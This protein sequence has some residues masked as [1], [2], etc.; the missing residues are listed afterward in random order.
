[1]CV[2]LVEQEQMGPLFRQGAAGERVKGNKVIM[3][4]FDDAETMLIGFYSSQ[5]QQCRSTIDEINTM[6]LKAAAA[7]YS[8]FPLN[9]PA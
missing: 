5:T 9:Q 8:Q 2:C 4:A 1:M 7:C 3:I 6:S